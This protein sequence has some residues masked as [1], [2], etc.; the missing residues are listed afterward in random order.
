M[1]L[2]FNRTRKAQVSVEL[3]IVLSMLLIILLVIISVSGKRNSMLNSKETEFYAKQVALQ[4]SSEIN[5][6][7]FAGDGINKTFYLPE[8]LKD[9]TQYNISIYPDGHVVDI[10]WEKNDRKSYSA[11][12]IAGNFNGTLVDLNGQVNL[13]NTLGVIQIN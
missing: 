6:I 11:S 10:V 5:A 7:H 1:E 13:S 2:R 3:I 4:F 12:I 8:D 9:G